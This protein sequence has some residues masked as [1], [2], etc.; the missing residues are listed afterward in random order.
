MKL[1]LI[2]QDL[3]VEKLGL[4][5]EVNRMKQLNSHLENRLQEQEKRLCLVTTEL[6]KTWHVVGKL[7]KHHYQLHTHEKIL[8]YE[9]QQKRK[10]LNEL[11]EELEYCRE[12]WDEAREKNSQSERDWKKLRAEFTSRK[13]KSVSPSFNN[14]GESGYSDER[15]S[16]ESSESNDESAYVTEQPTRCKKKMKKSFETILDSSTDFNCVAEREDPVSDLLDVAD[17]PLDT[18]D[19]D[20]HVATTSELS[21]SENLPKCDKTCETEDEICDITHDDSVIEEPARENQLTNDYVHED[22]I[23]DTETSTLQSELNTLSDNTLSENLPHTEQNETLAKRE[24]RLPNLNNS[25]SA[26]LNNTQ[27][28]TQSC[29]EISSTLEPLSVA[30]LSQSTSSFDKQ[31]TKTENEDNTETLAVAGNINL[32][33]ITQNLNLELNDENN[34]ESINTNSDEVLNSISNIQNQSINASVKDKTVHETIISTNPETTVV[35]FKAI[36]ENVQR[37]NE[38]L[39]IKDE[40]FDKLEENCLEVIKNIKSTLNTGQDMIE[41]LD[42]LHKEYQDD[43]AEASGSNCLLECDD[44]IDKDEPST[45]TEVGHEARFAARDIRLKRLEEQTKSLVNKV[46]KTNSKGV[47]IHY[48]LQELHNIYGSESSRAGTPS[49]E[50][51]NR[52][53]DEDND[54]SEKSVDEDTDTNNE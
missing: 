27:E 19:S 18:H 31:N 21:K 2:L 54:L 36:M 23:S 34:T 33:T 46:N 42:T 38:R 14:S 35:D 10:L 24:E 1:Y 28:T 12:K 17:L 37:Q 30:L 4:V 29:H 25:S 52:S 49:E 16:D 40:R 32:E 6:G 7:R 43:S 13:T 8:K 53:N 51:A 48:K 39:A 9:L 41:K 44:S 5:K 11:K 3:I 20:N 22:I 26:L 47:K 15:P 45:S 50:N